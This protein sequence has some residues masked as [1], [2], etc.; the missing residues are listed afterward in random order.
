[1]AIHKDYPGLKAEIVVNDKALPEYEDPN[2]KCEPNE[3]VRYVEAEAGAEFA[4]R[5]NYDKTLLKD[6]DL[7]RVAYVDGQ[8]IQKKT[9]KKG[10]LV[11]SSPRYFR[12]AMRR[13]DGRYTEQTLHFG[14]LV[15]TDEVSCRPA[16]DLR[17]KAKQLSEIILKLEFGTARA[18]IQQG[19]TWTR[20]EFTEATNISEMAIKGDEKSL[21]ARPTPGV[22]DGLGKPELIMLI[23]HYRGHADGLEGQSTKHLHLLLKFYEGQGAKVS[24][25]GSAGRRIKREH[26]AD[27]CVTGERK[28]GKVNTIVLDD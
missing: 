26:D 19:S 24:P 27:V 3:V 12:I 4:I 15:T 11:Q 14:E 17:K 10:A 9:T 28:R 8:S 23:E 22:L 18:I 13:L 16:K 7:R 1:M 20:K 25:Q 21:Q 2:I 6:H 5:Y